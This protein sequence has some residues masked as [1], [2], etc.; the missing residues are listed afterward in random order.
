M[1]GQIL[2]DHM[3]A[4]KLKG[5]VE[6]FGGLPLF[7]GFSFSNAVFNF[8]DLPRLFS[9]ATSTPVSTSITSST[10]SSSSLFY[11]DFIKLKN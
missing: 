2:G 1:A 10:N 9:L 5:S 8:F 6:N 3:V 7:L 11:I 4:G